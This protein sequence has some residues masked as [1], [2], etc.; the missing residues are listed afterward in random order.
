MGCRCNDIVTA[1]KDLN[2]LYDARTDV[3]TALKSYREVMES[4]DSFFKKQRMAFYL[5]EDEYTD[6]ESLIMQQDSE[7]EEELENYH[8][9]LQGEIDALNDKI[10]R[11]ESEDDSYHDDDDD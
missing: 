9:K 5:E 8:I 3:S 1:G 11:M 10:S 6:I 4:H 2:K 7:I